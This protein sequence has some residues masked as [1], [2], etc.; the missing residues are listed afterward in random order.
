MSRLDAIRSELKNPVGAYDL[1]REDK[2]SPLVG[3]LSDE[4]ARRHAAAHSEANADI[5]LGLC[6]FLLDE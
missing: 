4:F 6:A 3:M 5:E 2:K 1:K